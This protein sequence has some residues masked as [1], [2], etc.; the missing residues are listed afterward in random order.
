MGRLCECP[1]LSPF[2]E[3]KIGNEAAPHPKIGLFAIKLKDAI[4]LFILGY[5]LRSLKPISGNRV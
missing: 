4:H 2:N 1:N 5:E 3:Y